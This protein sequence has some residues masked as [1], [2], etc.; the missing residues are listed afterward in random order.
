MAAI[1]DSPRKILD[2]GANNG[3]D[4][5]YYLH[6]GCTVVAVDANPLLC[7]ELEE[8]FAPERAAGRAVILNVGVAHAGTESARFWRNLDNSLWSSFM[9][10]LAARNG[11]RTE[12]VEVP[13]R[14]LASLVTE[15]GPMHYI[16]IDVEG[17]D[18]VC[19]ETLT[20]ETA[21]PYISAELFNGMHAEK[22]AVLR[23]LGYRRF[24]LICGE[25]LST[26]APIFKMDLG[27]RLLR[28]TCSLFPPALDV[29]HRLPV[30]ARPDRIEF[31]NFRKTA[32]YPFPEGATGAFGEDTP[33]KWLDY[34]AAR[35]RTDW[36]L[37]G[38]MREFHVDPWYD[39]H[40][41]R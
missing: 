30:W 18:L 3:D 6:C 35:R 26:A 36:L 11:T 41:T 27:S 14:T 17:Y 24:K 1:L 38:F 31:D 28:K 16:K 37:N 12:P 15:Y 2:I 20:P 5:A 23:A 13:C 40:A 29:L 33:G 4:T 9:P 21:P 39:V 10:E 22:L 32:P 25:T 7:R 8:R 34:D 19:L